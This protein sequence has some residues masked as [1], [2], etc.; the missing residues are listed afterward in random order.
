MKAR[1]RTWKQGFLENKKDEGEHFNI[2]IIIIGNNHE[3]LVDKNDI[4]SIAH[5]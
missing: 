1:K 4:V 3:N 2:I 5:C